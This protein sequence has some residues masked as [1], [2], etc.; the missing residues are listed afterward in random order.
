MGITS[1]PV[2]KFESVMRKMENKLAKN[3]KE[4][5][6]QILININL[7]LEKNFLVN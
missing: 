6:F 3:E 4:K 1:K 5:K 7:G 2:G